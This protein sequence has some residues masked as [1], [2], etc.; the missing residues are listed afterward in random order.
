MIP[1]KSFWKCDNFA[2]WNK[3]LMQRDYV[4]APAATATPVTC[5]LGGAVWAGMRERVV[6]DACN[7]GRASLFFPRQEWRLC[8][9]CLRVMECS[10]PWRTA[11]LAVLRTRHVKPQTPNHV[12]Q[13]KVEGTTKE[14]EGIA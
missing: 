7:A 9:C 1:I 10:I 2:G 13:I 14:A 3:E 6:R 5:R 11:S 8:F 4:L 12:L